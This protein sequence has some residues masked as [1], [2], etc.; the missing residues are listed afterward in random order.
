MDKNIKCLVIDDE[1]SIRDLCKRALDKIDIE[2]DTAQSAEEGLEMIKTADYNVVL[3]DINL[4]GIDG[5]ELL[6]IV[7]EMHMNIDVI[8]I[9]GNATIQDAVTA[10]KKGAYDFITKPFDIHHI[11]KTVKKAI[12]I[13]DLK[14]QVNLLQEIVS[15]HEVSKLISRLIP[16]KELL[17]MV[18]KE[19]KKVLDAEESYIALCSNDND[20][21][22]IEYSDSTDPSYSAGVPVKNDN[23][24]D[25]PTKEINPLQ[26]NTVSD[27][28]HTSKTDEQKSKN[29]ISVP[30]TVKNKFIGTLNF[31]NKET[32][33]EFNYHDLKIASIF[34]QQA[35]FAI[36]NARDY[37]EL[38]TLDDMK[39]EFLANV[40][41][42]LKTPL[43]SITNSCE[44]LQKQDPENKMINILIRNAERM[45]TLIS[46][47]LDF[48]RMEK[49]G[50][51]LSTE[52]VDLKKMIIES[53]E[54]LRLQANKKDI[55]LED[56]LA[57]TGMIMI[58]RDAVKRVI[59]NIMDNAIK[60]SSQRS[61]VK[62]ST[63]LSDGMIRIEISDDGEGIPAEEQ[64]HL[65]ER[66]YQ[67]E[68]GKSFTQKPS[69]LGLGL[70]M[71]RDI[72]EAH[73]GRLY[74]ENKIGEGSTFIID[75]PKKE[76]DEKNTDI[77]HS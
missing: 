17:E 4:P 59:L 57:D 34:A 12:E 5:L 41:H 61:H 24:C 18:C 62:I 64:E 28:T 32:G 51:K 38:K 3:L 6:G 48:S 22:T 23:I 8:M 55:S 75:I 11:R 71:A 52:P 29:S 35:A 21:L 65:F 58:D 72:I 76:S 26:K 19:A 74:L 9:T 56:S 10:M 60:Y 68:P 2:T 70:A 69:G 67:K 73:E 49:S 30:M 43:Q 13:K 36:Q 66:F 33:S 1:Q 7:K 47:L 44:I 54:E 31:R 77:S 20:T 45:R 46:Q 16:I 42:E 53:V 63:S 15:I 40:S 50:F 14:S 37:E 27:E 25:I 39:S